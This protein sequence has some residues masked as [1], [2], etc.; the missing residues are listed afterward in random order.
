VSLKAGVTTV[1][2]VAGIAVGTA[3]PAAASESDYLRLKDSLNFLTT[4]Q[5]LTEGYRACGAVHNGVRSADVVNMVINDLGVSV[6][7]AL[8]IVAAAVVDLSF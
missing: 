4:Q 2:M 3:V 5:L 1:A 6:N 8:D 7:A